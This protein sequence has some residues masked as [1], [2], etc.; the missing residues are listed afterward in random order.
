MQRRKG[1]Q[2]ASMTG[3]LIVISLVLGTIAGGSVLGWYRWNARKP[4]RE[5]YPLSD[6]RRAVLRP[7]L[8]AGGRVESGRRTVIECQLENL[9]AG[10]QGQR[11]TTSGA[12]VLLKLIPEGTYVKKGDVL[13]VLDSSDY[14]ELL[15]L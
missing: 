11:I 1:S 9:S 5:R 7:T 14:V 3:R 6:V 8:R 12:S 15:R 13:A 2:P 4:A 10:V